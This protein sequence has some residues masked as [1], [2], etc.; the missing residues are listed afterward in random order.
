[1]SDSPGTLLIP[2]TFVDLSI[3]SAPA[4]YGTVLLAVLAKGDSKLLASIS[5][6]EVASMA[7]VR[8][9]ASSTVEPKAKNTT[10][11]TMQANNALIE[12]IYD[13][14]KCKVFGKREAKSKRYAA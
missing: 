7:S 9:A 4:R 10:W 2:F 1:M 12:A 14:E 11:S 6:E 8:F 13:L 3:S 5:S